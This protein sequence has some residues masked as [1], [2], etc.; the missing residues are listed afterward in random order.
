MF[1]KIKQVIKFA[2]HK[3]E[4]EIIGVSSGPFLPESTI[5]KKCTLCGSEHTVTL[6]EVYWHVSKEG[7]FETYINSI[8]K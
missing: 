8:P 4:W 5:V 3:H 7:K 1:N 2:V 6:G